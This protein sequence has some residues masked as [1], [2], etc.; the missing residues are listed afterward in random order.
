ME[1]TMRVYKFPDIVMQICNSL[2]SLNK[3]IKTKLRCQLIILKTQRKMVLSQ[4]HHLVKSI[5]TLL[6]LDVLSK[7]Y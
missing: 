1:E 3:F 7:N 4:L 6:I 5:Q 2:N